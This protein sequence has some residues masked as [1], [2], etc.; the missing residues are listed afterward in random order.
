M[1]VPKDSTA[2]QGHGDPEEL[3]IMLGGSWWWA[4]GYALATLVPGILLLVWPDATLHVLAVIVGLYLLVSGAVRFVTAFSG[5]RGQE[6]GRVAAVLV[7]VVVVLAGVL[8]LR[9][10]LQ[11]V[12]VMAL[13]VGLVWIAS[14]MLTMFAALSHRGLPHRGFVVAAAALGIV[15]GVVVLAYPVQ[16]AVAL[17]RLLGLWLILL[18][19]GELVVAFGLRA[20]THGKAAGRAPGLT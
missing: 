2:T 8:V 18:G 17:A 4:L 16:S 12:A 11:T 5:G 3:L 20:A 1:T 14:G 6:G 10:P 19:V 15:A 7:A 9:K 13:I